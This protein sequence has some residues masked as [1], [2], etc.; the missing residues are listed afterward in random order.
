M[1][2]MLD[3]YREHGISPVTQDITDLQAHF[4]RRAH[5]YRSLGLPPMAI[6]DKSVMEVG[7]GSGDNALYTSSLKPS[8][9][10]LVEP[11]AKACEDI[12]AKTI[13]QTHAFK[14]Y[15]CEIG[16]YRDD[17][18][19]FDVVLCEGFLGL[20]GGDSARMLEDV[21]KH[22]KVGGVLVITCI[23]A[24]SDHSEVLRRALA[25]R[26]I[27]NS[28]TL[29]EKVNALV[30]V[31][32]PHLATLKGI[33]RSVEDWIL[34]NILNPASIGPTFSIPD[35][36]THLEGRFEVLG[37]SP[38]GLIPD[39][40]WYKEAPQG[41]QWAIDAYWTQAHNL[42]D[43]RK[44]EHGRRATVN[45]EL[46]Q[47]CKRI[48]SIVHTIEH[49]GLKHDLGCAVELDDQL[50]ILEA[51]PGWFGRGQQYLSLVRVQ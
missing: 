42:L 35:A 49:G 12:K 9:Y 46:M 16:E 44:V 33:T 45:T 17:G 1:T 5:L 28:M 38:D 20:C 36:L 14:L 27:N 31:F 23:D 24:I 32:T 22:V 43:C 21:E 4:A 34:D 47:W 29:H 40:H 6:Q 48:R 13:S 3:F 30:P 2:T 25:Q 50:D 19:G 7:P 10:V 8:R 26:Y 11:N 18:I 15:Q 41:N 39:W 51:D 37:C